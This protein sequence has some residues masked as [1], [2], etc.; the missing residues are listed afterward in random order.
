MS[1]STSTLWRHKFE[2]VSPQLVI[3]LSTIVS[4]KHKNKNML[5]QRCSIWILYYRTFSLV[6]VEW[7]PWP[8]SWWCGGT[9]TTS[10]RLESSALQVSWRSTTPTTSLSMGS[11]SRYEMSYKLRIISPHSRWRCVSLDATCSAKQLG[12]TAIDPAAPSSL[13]Y[14]CHHIRV[15]CRPLSFDTEVVNQTHATYN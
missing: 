15:P 2:G 11:L 1:P 13:C 6:G 14:H 8:S 12:E 4:I 9:I 10:K 7:N 5:C 3:Q